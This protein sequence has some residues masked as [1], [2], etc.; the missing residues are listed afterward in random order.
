MRHV[1][2]CSFQA[3]SHVQAPVGG[4]NVLNGTLRVF[5]TLFWKV[6]RGE[7]CVGRL[8]RLVCW[9]TAWL[10]ASC[11]SEV[12][13]NSSDTWAVKVTGETDQHW[14]CL[15]GK[16]TSPLSKSPSTKKIGKREEGTLPPKPR[17]KSVRRSCA[18]RKKKQEGGG[19][20]SS[21]AAHAVDM[22]TLS[23]ISVVGVPS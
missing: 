13:F 9:Y 15:P 12:D 16:A 10:R 18:G 20:S 22:F 6:S 1:D 8:S 3:G 4:T 14:F 17:T 23:H 2:G 5:L 19:A 11:F 7:V 21:R